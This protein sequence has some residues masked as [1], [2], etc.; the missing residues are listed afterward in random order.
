MNCR[1]SGLKNA[2]AALLTFA[3]IILAACSPRTPLEAMTPSPTPQYGGELNV[4]SVYISL[5]ALSWDPAD[6][7]WKANHDAGAVREMLLAA[8]LKKARHNGGPYAFTADVFIPPDALRGELA[9]SWHWEDPLTLV[10]R[11]RRGVYFPDKPGVMKRRELDAQDVVYTFDYV[12]SSPRNQPT[13]LGFLDRVEA[14]DSHTVAF[15]LKEYNSEWDYRIG[16]GYYTSIIP[17]EM[18]DSDPRDWRNLV[19]SGPF[20]LSRYVSA[21]VASYER[22]QHYWDSESMNGASYKLPFV[23]KVNYRI[24]KDEATYLSA[25][26]TGKL[27]IVEIIRW[28]NVA[29]LKETTPELMWNRWLAPQ[30]T[31]IA[32]RVDRPPLDNVLVRRALNI[33]VDKQEI[34][35][36]YYGGEAEI[37]AF[38]QHP[39]FGPYFQP[40]EEMPASVQELFTYDPDK[41]RRLLAE[42]GLPEGFDLTVQVCSCTADHMDLLPLI[43]SYWEKIGVRVQIQSMEYAAFLSAMTTRTHAPGYL[44]N[45]GHVTPLSSLRKNF[46]AGQ[47]WNASQYSNPSFDRRIDEAFR[48]RDP[49]QQITSVRSL[50]AEIIDEAPYVWLPTPYLYTAWWPWVRNYGGELRAGAVRPGPI[51]ARL[52]IDHDMK[53][54]MGFE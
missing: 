35:R 15:H 24:I 22:N 20:S 8:D 33:A 36:I 10:I 31:Y 49:Q 51:Y 26:R 21:S 11:L 19:G 3:A 38:P 16:Y 29:H 18:A 54:R 4:G 12:R 2:G 30:G 28:I 43:M 6:W 37:M 7:T 41:A 34:A 40:L 23:D 44:M 25:L 50:T 14:R 32:L 9:E 53:R 45:T 48:M 5:S 52:W 42:A 17:R 13:Y 27:D 39:D 47:V 1:R 46:Q